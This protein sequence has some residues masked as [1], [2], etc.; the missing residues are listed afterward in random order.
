MSEIEDLET[1]GMS[2]RAQPMVDSH[3]FRIRYLESYFAQSEIQ[4][5]LVKKI[6]L[7]VNR[8]LDVI[9]RGS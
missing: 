8:R 4:W 7:E 6:L 9:E 3:E 1:P 5:N 2:M